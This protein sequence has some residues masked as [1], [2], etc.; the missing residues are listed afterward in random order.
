MYAHTGRRMQ[1]RPMR[2][3]PK[4]CLGLYRQQDRNVPSSYSEYKFIAISTCLIALLLCCIQ[5]PQ[6]PLRFMQTSY[7]RAVTLCRYSGNL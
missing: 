1:M 6:L 5:W 7:T 2:R 4:D 3:A